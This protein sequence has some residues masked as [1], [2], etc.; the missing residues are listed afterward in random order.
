[1]AVTSSVEP[2]TF[3]IATGRN[4]MCGRRPKGSRKMV[5]KVKEKVVVKKDCGCREIGD[6]VLFLCPVHRKEETEKLKQIYH[7]CV[8]SREAG[9]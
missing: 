3:A 5:Q 8:K 7:K 4:R 9:I 1:M 6:Q 2:G